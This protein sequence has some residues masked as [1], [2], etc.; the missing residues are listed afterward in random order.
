MKILAIGAH[1]DDVEICCF[2]TLARC[3]SRGDS[4][5]VCSVTN[6]NQGHSTLDVDDMNLNHTNSDV[7]LRMTELIRSVQPDVLMTH[8]S[9]D[10][11]PDHNETYEL[12]K[13]S[14]IQSTLVH[15]KTESAPLNKSITLYHMDKVGG[16]LFIPTEYVDI[17]ETFSLKMKALESHVSQLNYL[18]KN[19]Q[20]PLLFATETLSAYRGLQC[21]TR[22][23]EAFRVSYTRPVPTTRILP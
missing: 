13:Y 1:P 21:S 11:H 17:T 16:G 22:Y 20:I 8:D 23:A 9:D 4:V 7:R 14:L 19:M 2:G 12:V 10:Y 3:V 5:V 15:C 6:G 18:E